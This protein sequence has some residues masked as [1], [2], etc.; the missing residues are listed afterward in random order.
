MH[1]Y[2]DRSVPVTIGLYPTRLDYMSSMTGTAYH[3]GV[4]EFPGFLMGSVLLL[5]MVLV[6]C[7]VFCFFFVLCLV[8][9]LLPVP[10]EC[11]FLIAPSVFSNICLYWVEG[12]GLWCSTTLSTNFS[13]AV[14]VCFINLQTCSMSLTY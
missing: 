4:H 1:I 9:P 6:F 2:L 8:C 12:N 11:S 3:W 14:A 10:L 7:V 13:Y 5:L